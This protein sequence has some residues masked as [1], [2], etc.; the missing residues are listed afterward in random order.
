MKSTIAEIITLHF[1]SKKISLENTLV[2]HLKCLHF[3]LTYLSDFFLF[4]TFVLF[5][6]LNFSFFQ[7]PEEEPEFHLTPEEATPLYPYACRMIVKILKG[8]NSF[9]FTV[10]ESWQGQFVA[11]IRNKTHCKDLRVD[12]LLVAINGRKVL[13]KSST[14]ILPIIRSIKEGELATFLIERGK[15]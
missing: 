1:L 4:F 7:I 9:E 3:F 15:A 6:L 12:D 14:A 8:R 13:R 5:T 11:E 2:K 10:V